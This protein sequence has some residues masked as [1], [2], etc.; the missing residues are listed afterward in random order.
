[1]VMF[2]EQKKAGV[3]KHGLLKNP[4]FEQTKPP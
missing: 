2:M 1:M 3:I 4:P